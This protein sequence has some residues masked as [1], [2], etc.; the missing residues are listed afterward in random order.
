MSES[1]TTDLFLGI[2]RLE[3]GV[4]RVL[5]PGREEH[6]GQVDGLRKRVGGCVLHAGLPGTALVLNSC[7]TRENNAS[8]YRR[9][10][11]TQVLG[12]FKSSTRDTSPQGANRN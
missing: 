7:G 10:A 3:P 6:G 4:E 5:H 9:N 11:G 8:D 2:D 12:K 1:R